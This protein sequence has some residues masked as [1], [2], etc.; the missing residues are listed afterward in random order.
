MRQKT[1]KQNDGYAVKFKAEVEEK[2]LAMLA[3]LDKKAED[4]WGPSSIAVVC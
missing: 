4:L 3:L 1:A 2:K